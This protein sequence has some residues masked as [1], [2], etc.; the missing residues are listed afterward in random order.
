[1]VTTSIV[2]APFVRYNKYTYIINPWRAC[3]ARVTVVG[4]V[5]V[6]TIESVDSI[7][8]DGADTPIKP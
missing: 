4:S 1:M 6:S 7:C 2:S 5:C 8:R 3:A